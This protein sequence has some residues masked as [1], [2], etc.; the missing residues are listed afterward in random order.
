MNHFDPKSIYALAIL[1]VRRHKLIS[2]VSFIL[3]LV[4]VIAIGVLKKPVYVSSTTVYMKTNNYST[5]GLDSRI[6]PPR[7]LGIQFAILK[8]E[9]LSEKVVESLP[10]ATLHDLETN[11]EYTDYGTNVINMIRTI[12]GRH[13]IVISPR[14]KAAME[15]KNAR[16]E[17][18]GTGN[19]GIIRISAESQT[20]QVSRDLANAYIDVFKEISSHFATEQQADLDKSLS[21]QV[22]NARSLLRKSENELLTF[23]NSN[24]TKGVNGSQVEVE[25]FYVQESALLRNL[26]R[27]KADLLITETES[28]PD[29][30]ATT[31][32]IGEVEKKLAALKSISRGGGHKVDISGPAWEVFLQSNVKMDRDFMTELEQERSSLRIIADSNLENIIVIDPPSIPVLPKMSKSLKIMGIGVVFAMLGA[33][34]IPFMLVFFRKPVQGEE[35]L[36]GLSALQ[37]LASIPMMASQKGATRNGSKMLRVDHPVGTPE[38]WAF[39]KSFETLYFRIKQL[40]KTEKDQIIF[41]TSQ[42]SGEGKSLAVMNLAL[43]MASW[44]N[45]V[46]VFDADP[47]FG[48]MAKSLNS[49]KYYPAKEFFPRGENAPPNISWEDSNIAILSLD[50]NNADIWR[51]T[52][53]TELFK[54]FELLRFQANFI[55]I[56]SPPILAAPDLLSLSAY[57]DQSIIV[58]RN[59]Q[60]LER[61]VLRTETLLREHNFNI[62]GT[63]LNG[64]SSTHSAYYSHYAVNAVA[65]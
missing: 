8:S 23:Q 16:M 41:F 48:S 34:G 59:N 25:N 58:V 20:P 33:I 2:T 47:V 6:H 12:T 21:L 62:L 28:H 61:E 24:H 43:T 55:L 29:V 32:E 10:E 4:P 14:R 40:A 49:K 39:Q 11:A 60:S 17:F 19:E 46:I 56:D 65:K 37:N 31:Q 57:V 45:R 30:L 51:T 26:K 54:G 27:R 42:T 64:A 18:H 7:S 63:I 9:F 13:P 53:D 50:K 22:L 15:L 38:F 5:S 52:P 44:G 36:K 1:G 3:F 35:N